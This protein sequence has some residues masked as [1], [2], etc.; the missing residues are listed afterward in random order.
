MENS[1]RVKDCI[2][3]SLM[4]GAAGDALGY[5]VE[6]VSR[7]SILARYGQRGITRFQLDSNGKALIS[8]DTQMTLFTANGLLWGL[9]RGRLR[10]IGATLD[11]YVADAYV[12]WYYTQTGVKSDDFSEMD[13]HATWLRDLPELAHRRAPGMT[14]MGA[15]EK[16]RRHEKVENDS[17]G[18]GGI[19]R[20]A[21][22]GLL[23]AA[24]RDREGKDFYDKKMLA[25]VGGDIARITHQHPLGWL[26]AALLTLLVDRLVPLTPTEAKESFVGIVRE[27]LSVMMQMDAP[28]EDKGYLMKLTMNA[29][30]LALSELPDHEAIF[31][32]GEGWT[33]EEA[34]AIALFCALRHID[35]L[36]AAIIAAVNH[37]G[38]SDSTG[39]VTGNIMGAIYGYRSICDERLFCPDGKRFEDTLELHN[40]I[41]ALADDLSAECPLSIYEPSDTPEKVRW[42]ERY[43]NMKPA[44]E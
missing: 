6:F 14:C 10:G 7:K 16:L 30:Q 1:Q 38:D 42:E 35:S 25:K 3:G 5:T 31:R 44:L 22:L 34:W 23:N 33:G 19:M 41:L 32:L 24:F 4:A 21:P 9:T 40:I 8:D 13:F 17:K 29:I 37:D 36:P 15:C 43:C 26:P 11:K 28:E 12:D 20:V 39:A 18:C 2:R 27:N